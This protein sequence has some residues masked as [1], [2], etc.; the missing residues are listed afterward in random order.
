MTEYIVRK[1]DT[2]EAIVSSTGTP[3]D[4]ILEALGDQD[5]VGAA[6]R[7]DPRLTLDAIEAAL[8]FARTAVERGGTYPQGQSAGVTGVRERARV[9]G[10]GTW[11]DRADAPAAASGSDPV[12]GAALHSA[13]RE[14]ERLL[15]ELELIDGLITGLRQ[16]AEGDV[17]PHE[18]VFA[19]LRERLWA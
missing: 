17:T 7:L 18:E 13:E 10:E 8:L 14:R 12:I 6:L 3:V 19:S 5:A 4:A 15:E 16:A 11:V 2:G 1:S 9:Q